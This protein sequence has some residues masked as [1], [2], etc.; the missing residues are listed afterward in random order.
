MTY[1][2]FSGGDRRFPV[3]RTIPREDTRELE[4]IP[5]IVRVVSLNNVAGKFPRARGIRRKDAA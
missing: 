2:R 5:R 4:Y 3:L 1:Q